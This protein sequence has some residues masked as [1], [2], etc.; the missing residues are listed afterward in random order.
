MLLFKELYKENVSTMQAWANF[1]NILCPILLGKVN[2]L[3]ISYAHHYNLQFVHFLSHFWK[4]KT[5]L[6]KEPFLQNSSLMHGYCRAGIFD[7]R[8]FNFWAET[9]LTILTICMS[10]NSK[11]SCLHQKLNS[12][13]LALYTKTSRKAQQVKTLKNVPLKKICPWHPI[14]RCQLAKKEPSI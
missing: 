14:S 10:K 8:H 13:L 12:V 7:L 3:Y 5:V 11:Y 9:Q 4:R 2:V 6:F 1:L